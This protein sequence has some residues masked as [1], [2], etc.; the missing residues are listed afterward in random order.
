MIDFMFRVMACKKCDRYTS[1]VQLFNEDCAVLKSIL[2]DMLPKK[3]VKKEEPVDMDEMQA[4][5][6]ANLINARKE[7]HD[8]YIL[9]PNGIIAIID[10]LFYLVKENKSDSIISIP[11]GWH[12]NKV[13]E[14]LQDVEEELFLCAVTGVHCTR[15]NPGP[16]K[17]RREIDK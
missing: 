15:C 6:M 2:D 9:S 11:I 1:C 12:E 7:A 17:H 5:I 3:D 14:S 13:Y 16:C 4:M 10:A 8:K